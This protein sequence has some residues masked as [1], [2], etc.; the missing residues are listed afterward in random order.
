MNP[1]RKELLKKELDYLLL[2]GIIIECEY[3]YASPVVLIPKPNGSM[4]LCIDYRKLNAQTVPDSYPLPRM[5]DLLNEAEPTPYTLTIDLRL[6]YHQEGI[7]VDPQKTAAVTDMTSP[8]SVKQ[9]QSF[10][11]TCSWYRR[12]ISNFSQ[13]VKPLTDLTKK[14]AMWKCGSEEC[15]VGYHRNAA[16]KKTAKFMSER[17]E[18]YIIVTQR[19]PTTYEVANPNNPR[20]VLGPYHSS[21][22]RPCIYKEA[23]PV[24]PLR[25]R[26]RPR[27]DNSAGSSSRTIPRN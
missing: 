24:M 17:D 20:E 8:I 4:R 2:Q 18:P 15:Q 21:A 7:S 27:K 16:Y 22:L 11:Q 13:I 3:P 23:T 9:V 12:Y 10:V 14:N 25:K 6:G 19:S 26:G 5:D 1:A